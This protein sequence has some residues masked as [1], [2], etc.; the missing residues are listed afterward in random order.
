MQHKLNKIPQM[1][2]RTFYFAITNKM[3]E[4]HMNV[5]TIVCMFVFPS[6]NKILN[7]IEETLRK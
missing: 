5:F 1:F 3:K 7:D 6:G 2:L 4:A